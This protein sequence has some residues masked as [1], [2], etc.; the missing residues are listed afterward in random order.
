MSLVD[1]T[2]LAF[3]ESNQVVYRERRDCTGTKVCA[4][5]VADV[6]HA[7]SPAASCR[8]RIASRQ[9]ITAL[10]DDRYHATFACDKLD[11]V[12]VCRERHGTAD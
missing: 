10:Q 12:A 5:S 4:T 8:H 11:G 1:P 6:H 7:K 3:L 2:I 9:A